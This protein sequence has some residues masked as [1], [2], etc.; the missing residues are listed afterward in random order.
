MKIT[1][2]APAFT[3]I[4]ITIET[5]EEAIAAVEIARTT[6]DLV[7]IGTTVKSEMCRKLV[8]CCEDALS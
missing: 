2:E 6:L 4:V 1:T 5:K 3:P 8:N 7:G